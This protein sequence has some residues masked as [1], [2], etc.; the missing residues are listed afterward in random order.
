MEE[1]KVVEDQ[2]IS[3]K[4]GP[5]DFSHEFQSKL[6]SIKGINENENFIEFVSKDEIAYVIL[7]DQ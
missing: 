6:D 7:V 2:I 5:K 3:T 1:E 4:E